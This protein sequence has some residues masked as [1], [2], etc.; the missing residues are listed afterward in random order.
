MVCAGEPLVTWRPQ[1]SIVF[2]GKLTAKHHFNAF[3][4][5][6]GGT[7]RYHPAL[8]SIPTVPTVEEKQ[9]GQGEGEG[10]GE[11]KEKSHKVK[12]KD[13]VLLTL[14]YTPTELDCYNPVH[15]ERL[16]TVEKRTPVLHWA[17]SES[18]I[19]YGTP[20]GAKHLC[21]GLSESLSA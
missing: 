20:L 18:T 12:D 14:D 7:F 1:A 4:D 13:T 5:L 3:A 9:D 11:G 21:A 6:P 16:L 2:E 17:L 8:G 15:L 10:Q 19:T